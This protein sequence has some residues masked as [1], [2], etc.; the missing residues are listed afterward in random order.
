MAENI[1]FIPAN[2]LPVAESE[3]VSVLCLENGEMKQK[4]GASLGGEK[5]DLVLR[6]NN[7]SSNF[8]LDHVSIVSG[9]V[10]ALYNAFEEGRVPNV[11]VEIVATKDINSWIVVRSRV[12]ANVIFYGDIAW[13]TFIHVSA[14]T[15]EPTFC[16]ISFNSANNYSIENAEYLFLQTWIPD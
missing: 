1:E 13:I 2:E 3:E 7:H 15:T 5:A 10:E 14:G 8:G 6:V 9:S 11:E 16:R 4:P 12:K